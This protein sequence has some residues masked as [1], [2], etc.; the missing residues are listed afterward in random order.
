LRNEYSISERHACQ[1]MQMHR[2]SYRYVGQQELIDAAY[3]EV[4]RLSQRYPYFGYRKIYDLMRDSW[5]ISR[6][7][8]RLIR[9]R[10][11]LQVVKKR[12]K[13]KLLGMTTQWVNRAEYP[14]HVWSYDFVYDQTDDGRQLK[15]L[16]VVDEFSRQG[17]A[18]RLGRSLTATDVT[19][20]LDELFREHG[21]P[22][23]LR[24][25][26]GPELVSRHVQNWLK[27]KHVDTHYI[28]PG[29]PW[30]NAYN[31]SFN[32]IFRTTCLDRCLFG[33]MTEA[34]VIIDHWLDEYNTVRP[35]G[36]LGGM[37]PEKFL[38]RWTEANIDQQPKSLTG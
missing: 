20:I 18:I 7:R 12:R 6:E 25:D 24:S 32:S 9:R 15:C 28:E 1:V 38:Q 4:V 36:S 21:R 33:S 3:R 29:S 13:R 35:H 27:G 8:V 26:N 17:L 14:N 37:T 31:E 30:Q 22:V 19:R 5:R 11:G 34:R 2:S 16:T 10:E 23:C